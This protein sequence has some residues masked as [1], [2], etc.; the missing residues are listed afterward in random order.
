[1]KVK[2]WTSRKIIL[3][4]KWRKLSARLN[5]KTKNG[6]F[7]QLSHRQQSKLLNKLKRCYQQLQRIGISAK[8]I[9]IGGAL[10]LL[11]ATP[12]QAQQFTQQTGAN[13]PFDGVNVGD[14]PIPTLVDIDNDGDFDAFIGEY[15]GNINYY[16][17]TGTN[18]APIFTVQTGA[19]NPLDAVN[20]G[21]TSP[22]FVDIDND[23]D[24]DAFIGESTGI[25]NYYENTGTNAAPSFTEQA[26][27][28]NPLD[29]LDVGFY[30]S[31]SF[32]DIDNDGDFD[33]F[34][35][36]HDGNI[37]YYRNAGTNT[38]PSF[39][40][41]TGANNPF[42]G[43]DVGDNSSPSFVDIDNDGDFDAFIGEYYGTIKYY[44]NTGTNAAPSF[45]VQTGAN[46]PLDGVNVTYYSIPSFADI[47]G[48]GD[49][50]AFIGG[51][52]EDVSYYRNTTP[53]PVELTYLRGEM[54]E[55]GTLLQWQTASEQNNKGFEIQR[56]TD[57]QEWKTLDFVSGNGTTA[58][59]S[60]YTFTDRE[61]FNGKN[62]YRLKQIDFDGKFEYSPIINIITGEADRKTVSI[63][64]NPIQN[65]LNIIDGQG[66]A[67]IYNVIGQSVKSFSI[68]QTPF[69]INTSDLPKGQ[70]ILRIQQENG[71]LNTQQFIK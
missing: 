38:A 64:P 5:Q 19:N 45:M 7:Y 40:I 2:N 25:I 50:D 8:H 17:N 13:N 1:M 53:L 56:S 48:D 16:K 62:Y 39:S 65:E 59:V 6:A 21:Y 9:A 68:L 42:D 41:E 70:Y 66:Q 26:G 44:R 52:D 36:E 55:E 35:G 30:S 12:M 10:S 22:T 14:R 57:D 71:E 69:L 33:A 20:L 47:D 34:V 3:L 43:V 31:P 24:F 58:E 18:A 27:I 29:E 54:T 46:N 4:K 28:N 67:T 15:A 51:Y 23:G 49:L 60:N 37:N 32:V 63:F 11:L 61:P